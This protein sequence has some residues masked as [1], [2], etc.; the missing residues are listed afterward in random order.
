MDKRDIA[1]VIGVIGLIMLGSVNLK[2][3]L[4]VALFVA[5]HR[6]AEHE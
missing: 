2:I 1:L 6:I 4:G 3:S 5:A